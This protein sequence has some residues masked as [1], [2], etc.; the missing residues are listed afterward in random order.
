MGGAPHGRGV[1]GGDWLKIATRFLIS[2]IVGHEQLGGQACGC[3]PP[4]KKP[5]S[6]KGNA[7]SPAMMESSLGSGGIP[8]GGGTLRGDGDGD[9]GW[10][11]KLRLDAKASTKTSKQRQSRFFRVTCLQ[12]GHSNNIAEQ[13]M[14]LPAQQ[15][16]RPPQV[17]ASAIHC[18]QKKRPERKAAGRRCCFP[19]DSALSPPQSGLASSQGLMAQGLPC[20]MTED[21]QSIYCPWDSYRSLDDIQWS[22]YFDFATWVIFEL[23]AQVKGLKDQAS[24]EPVEVLF[25]SQEAKTLDLWITTSDACSAPA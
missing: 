1:R 20:M 4:Q 13:N 23:E 5:E 6:L 18:V 7:K 21:L 15:S 14:E 17:R 19:A 2:V 3:Q 22:S 12:V 11:K 16:C 25:S 24:K 9:C 10:P 8:G